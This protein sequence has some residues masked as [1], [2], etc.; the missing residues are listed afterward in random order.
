[1][2]ATNTNTTKFKN[3]KFSW[4]MITGLI[5]ATGI[6]GLFLVNQSKPTTINTFRAA[7][8]NHVKP[9]IHP[10]ARP[11]ALV[12]PTNVRNAYNLSTGAVGSGTIAIVDAYDDP[13]AQTD[14]AVFDKQFGLAVC[15]T[16]NNCFEQ[17]K[18]T[19]NIR[20]NSDWAVEEAL[21]VQWAHAIAPGA[22]IL[23]VE[24]ATDSGTNLLNAINYARSRSDV[25]AVSLSWG[26]NEFPTEASFESNLT[27]PYG[28]T[29]F[30]AAGD[31]GHGTAWPAASANVVAVGGSSLKLDANGNF[32]SES[33]WAD[34]GGGLSSYIKEPA[35]Q[36]S[37]G[38]PQ[39]AGHRAMPDVAYNADPNSGYAVYDST[40]YFGYRGWFQVGGTSAGTP[41]WAALRAIDPSLTAAK[42]YGDAKSTPAD[43]RDITTGT[44]GSCGFF[45]T[46]STGYDYTTGLGSPLTKA[47]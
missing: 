44:N 19:N 46:A 6:I 18:M 22:K 35:W 30:A 25:V 8:F 3:T 39:A 28:A 47:F 41:Q 38:V 37:Y 1:M 29:F 2:N 26:G 33:A 4:L 10:S 43:F 7:P 5:I 20:T 13:T 27:S 14:L 21:D 11:S 45:C 12:S 40:P 24:A 9:S 34:G 42:L 31:D 17:H 15:T 23:L 32:I 16:A 36:T